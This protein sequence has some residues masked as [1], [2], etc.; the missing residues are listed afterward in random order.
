M[1]ALLS[2]R[3]KQN[4]DLVT[5]A[6]NG[7]LSPELQTFVLRHME[8]YFNENF[9]E[10]MRIQTKASKLVNDG[11]WKYEKDKKEQGFIYGSLAANQ[12]KKSSDW[13][14]DVPDHFEFRKLYMK[15][16][17]TYTVDI[18]YLLTVV[19]KSSRFGPDLTKLAEDVYTEVRNPLSHPCEEYWTDVK[20]HESM[21]LI[22]GL[23][24]AIEASE[25]V[26]IELRD[27]RDRNVEMLPLP[28]F[29]VRFMMAASV[30]MM[31][32]V[33]GEPLNVDVDEAVR[34]LTREERSEF[35]RFANDM[36][37]LAVKLEL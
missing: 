8:E 35:D 28:A 20:H 17:M 29:N 11:G 1:D 24:E 3:N 12:D 27:C 26:L 10:K 19:K 37:T 2:R 30:Q 25:D 9:R 33:L 34:P 15:S 5:I 23:A 32:A 21:E 7:I 31:G 6:L 18:A 13:T 16:F 36:A 14:F 4:F 22:I